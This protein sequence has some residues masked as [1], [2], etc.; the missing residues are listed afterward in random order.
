MQNFIKVLNT[1]FIK[2]CMVIDFMVLTKIL[3]YNGSSTS[4]EGFNQGL[5]NC[6]MLKLKVVK[7]QFLFT[8]F[9]T[10]KFLKTIC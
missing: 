4:F 2:H 8:N 1:F 7:S 5:N 10:K 3:K 9:T 6:A